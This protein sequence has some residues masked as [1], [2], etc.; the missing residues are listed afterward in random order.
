MF[1]VWGNPSPDI[2]KR[3]YT[4]I[5]VVF[6][7]DAIIF[8]KIFFLL[9]DLIRLQKVRV[10]YDGVNHSLDKSEFMNM[11]ELLLKLSKSGNFEKIDFNQPVCVELSKFNKEILYIEQSGKIIYPKEV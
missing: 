11:T 5:L 8:R 7:L 10:Y 6:I 1:V 3:T 2:I 9:I 4:A